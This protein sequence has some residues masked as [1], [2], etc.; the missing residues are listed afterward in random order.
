MKQKTSHHVTP[1]VINQIKI[2][3]MTNKEVRELATEIVGD[4]KLPN[5]FFV[6]SSPYYHE[7]DEYGDYDSHILDGFEFDEPESKVFD[8]FEEAEAYYDD[9]ELDIYD[10]IGQVV[11]EDRLTGTIK[12]KTLKKVVRVEYIMT[13]T[14][15]T[16]RFGYKK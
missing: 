8:T 7:V 5:K 15:D 1:F 6:T 10:G 12:E 16:Y 11:I 3:V 13:E 9:I 14:D 2:K 4:G